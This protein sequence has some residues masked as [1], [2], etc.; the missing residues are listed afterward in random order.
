MNLKLTHYFWLLGAV[1]LFLIV[2][3]FIAESMSEP[4]Y[5]I[6]KEYTKNQDVQRYE[7]QVQDSNDLTTGSGNT[8]VRT[9]VNGDNNQVATVVGNNNAVVVGDNIRHAQ[10]QGRSRRH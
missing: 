10:C 4:T 1:A 9:T 7:D 8:I 6:D 2:G 3:F 5:W